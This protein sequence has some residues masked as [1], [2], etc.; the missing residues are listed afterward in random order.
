MS[1]QPSTTGVSRLS[2]EEDHELR[3]LTWFSKVGH[4]SEAS[5]ARL[6]E[7]QDRDR[8]TDVRDPRPDPS[9]EEEE[10]TATR[11]PEP[12]RLSGSTCPNCGFI[13]QDGPGLRRDD[14]LQRPIGMI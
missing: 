7:L 4:L 12:D 13:L 6:A 3:Q 8:R 2:L 1:E 9:C 5:T 10:P 14:L 11:L